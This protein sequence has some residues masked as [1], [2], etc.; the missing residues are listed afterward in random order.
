LESPTNHKFC[1][2]SMDVG[3]VCKKR[4]K[5]TKNYRKDTIKRVVGQLILVL[6]LIK[7]LVVICSLFGAYDWLSVHKKK[8]QKF[9]WRCWF[10]S[11]RKR[12]AYDPSR[13]AHCGTELNW[14]MWIQPPQ[15][16]F[17][18]F[19]KMAASQTI[20][21]KFKQFVLFS[22]VSGM[23]VNVMLSSVCW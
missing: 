21:Q 18:R 5:W 3:M 13:G 22:K 2:C 16:P 4:V 1:W 14:P 15:T 23:N 17:H 6:Q 7:L 12:F 19:L 11:F 9:L 20:K 10:L 8:L